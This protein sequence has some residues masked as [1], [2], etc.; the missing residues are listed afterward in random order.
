MIESYENASEF[1][2]V[3]EEPRNQGAWTHVRERLDA[4]VKGVK[5]EN[6]GVVF[7]GRKED[8]VPAPGVARYYQ[9]QQREVITSAFE[10][11]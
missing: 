11:F 8:A 6:A 3:Q 9:A 4:L 2:W 1:V 10:A 7:R 5:G